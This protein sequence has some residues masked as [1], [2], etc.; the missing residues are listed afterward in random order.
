MKVLFTTTV[1]SPYR[2]DFFNELGK[3]CDLTV[4]FE[5]NKFVDRDKSW[6]NF[7]FDNFDGVFLS[8]NG[9]SSILSDSNR[10][11]KIIKQ[12]VFDKI[13]VTNF[14][15]PIGILIINFLK[16]TKT[17]YYLESDGAFA[18]DCRGLKEKFKKHIISGATG[19]FS[20]A[21]EHDKYYC[22]Y[23]APTDKLIRYHFSSVSNADLISAL[24]SESN[25]RELREK[26]DIKEEK[27]VL[28]IGQFIHRKGFDLLIRAAANVSSEVGFYFVG[29]EPTEEYLS[30][31]RELNL[32]NVHFVGFKG[33]A[34][35]KEYYLAADVFVHPTRLDIWGLVVNEAMAHGLPVITT[36]KC[37]A[38]LEMVSDNRML[39]EED[40]PGSLSDAINLLLFDKKLLNKISIDNLKKAAEYTVETMSADHINAFNILN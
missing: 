1:P 32:D 21:D 12:Q 13:V 26:L 17:P 37:I 33:K 27:V 40:N 8:K 36:T 19:Y 15:T 22:A 3:Y 25:K 14:S 20:T 7:K 38:G 24:I 5:R 23:G 2:V 35:L 29:G 4:I 16:R 30:L 39:V 6:E 31:K 18:K 9:K 10:A 28:A 11:I 34:E